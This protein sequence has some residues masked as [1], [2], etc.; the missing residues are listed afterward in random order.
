[1]LGELAIVGATPA[2]R[3]FMHRLTARFLL[4]F[5]LVGNFVPLAL[6]S[7]AQK[8]HACCARK[9]ARP[10]HGGAIADSSRLSIHDASCCNHDCCRAVTTAQWAHPHPRTATL[11]REV[12]SRVL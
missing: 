2:P 4:L 7:V 10:C 9:A 6:A 8:P 12:I 11:C 3:I 5:A 1:M